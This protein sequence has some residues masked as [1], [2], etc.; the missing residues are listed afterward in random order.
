MDGWL[1]DWIYMCVYMQHNLFKYWTD[2]REICYKYS[3]PYGG[4]HCKQFAFFK[5]ISVHFVQNSVLNDHKN[6][7]IVPRVSLPI[8][9]LNVLS[10]DN[11]RE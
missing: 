10:S 1:A 4:D 8:Q 5:M 6:T 7:L 2:S 3:L 9:A 11:R